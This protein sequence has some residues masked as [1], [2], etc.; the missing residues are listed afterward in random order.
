MAVS[1]IDYGAPLKHHMKRRF[2]Q[3]KH[4][5]FSDVV[6]TDTMV[7]K[8]DTPSVRGY[9][10]AQVFVAQRSRLVKVYLMKNRSESVN[11]LRQFFT[12]VGFPDHLCYDQAG[13]E[14]SSLR[15]EECRIAKVPTHQSEAYHQHQNSA[16]GAI[17]DV[18]AM[19]AKV[20]SSSDNA[21]DKYWCYVT[22]LAAEL[23]NHLASPS[24]D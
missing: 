17:R 3:F 2:P 8:K 4:K 9:R 7:C 10:Y 24:I 21:P 5:R 15:D 6:N 19:T 16:E 12:D 18:K 13:E 1:E 23:I 22:E 14:N 11:T 20:F